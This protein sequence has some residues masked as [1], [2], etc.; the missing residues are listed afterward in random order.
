MGD[1]FG[2]NPLLEELNLGSF[3]ATNVKQ[4]D[5]MF[6]G[7]NNLRKVVF[8]SFETKSL[9]QI[10]HMFY[11]CSNLETI[12]LS[13]FKFD[14]VSTSDKYANMFTNIKNNPTIIVKDE[15]AKNFIQARI[16]EAEKTATIIIKNV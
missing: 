5:Y 3:D 16:K 7:C 14:R 9:N 12:D 8:S 4:M 13:A 2:D 15:N 1:M 11:N 6:Y 10:N